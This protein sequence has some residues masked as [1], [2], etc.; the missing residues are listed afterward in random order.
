MEES[1]LNRHLFLLHRFR[2]ALCTF[3]WG[4]RLISSA[5]TKLQKPDRFH[6]K[7]MIFGII[8][9]CSNK[10]GWQQ[11]WRKLNT[12]EKDSHGF[13]RSCNGFLFC[14]PQHSFKHMSIGTNSNPQGALKDFVDQQWFFIS[15]HF[16][17]QCI[18]RRNIHFFY[19]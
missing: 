7:G 9:S 14:R 4:A 18:G 19:S 15:K 12:A 5:R 11:I 1:L 8:D 6:R 3:T 10:I 16:M 2:R 13:A 17:G